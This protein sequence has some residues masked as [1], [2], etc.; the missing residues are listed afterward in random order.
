[1]LVAVGVA[2]IVI[3]VMIVAGVPMIMIMAVIMVM[4]MLGGRLKPGHLVLD[5]LQQLLHGDLLLGRLGLLDD[6]VDHLVLED[7]PR[8]LHHG[9]GVLLVELVDHALL[10]GEA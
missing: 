9:A 1:M 2:V 4:L 5:R 3:V 7:R 10:A 8:E 6:V